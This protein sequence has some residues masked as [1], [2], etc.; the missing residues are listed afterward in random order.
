MIKAIVF[1]YGGVI[2][3]NSSDLIADICDYLKINK[4]DWRREYFAVNHLFNVENKSFEEV[5][6]LVVSKFDNS[7]ETKKYILNLLKDNKGKYYLNDELISII[8]DLKSRDYIIA[9][10]SNNSI[11]LREKLTEEGITDLFDQIIVSAEVGYQKPQ[12]EIFQILFN[13]L[14]LMP[15][16]VVFI[17][18]STRSLEGAD[19][20]G[21]VPILYK[22]NEIFKSELSIILKDEI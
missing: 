3:I 5:F 6:L 2:K 17:D 8:K 14:G 9:L 12:P 22:N 21:Y 16:E 1:D 13:K 15:E 18:D 20:I 7:E 19:K 4:E 10:L 11:G